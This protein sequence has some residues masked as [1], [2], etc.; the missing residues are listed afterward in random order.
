MLIKRKL[1]LLAMVSV[2]VTA[3]AAVERIEIKERAP[4]APGVTYGEAG[5]YEKIRGIAYFALDPK[6]AANAAIVDLKRAPRDARGRVLFSSEFI[7]LRPAGGLPSSLIYDVNNRGGIAMLGQ[8]NGRSPANND[9]ATAADAGDGFLMR[10]GFSMLFSAW[11]WDVAPPAPGARPLVFAPP[12][13]QGVKGRVQNEFTVNAPVDIATY[14]GMRGLTYEPATPNDPHAQL[15]MRARPGD[16]RRLVPR[17]SWHFVAPEQ[18]G[19]PGRVRLDDGFKPDT[20]YE[21]TYVAKDPYVTGAGLAGIR[22]LLAY[23]RDKPFEGAPVPKNVL[24]FGISQSGRVIGRMLHDGLN[25]DESGQLVFSGAY[26]HVP[27][28]GGSAGF[29]SRFAQP[30]RHPSM[31]EE[32][33]YP[34]DAFPF[35]TAPSRDPV[36]GQT[37][38]YLDH[39][40]DKQGRL[41]KL[42]IA[43]TSTEFWNRGASLIA[44][45]PDGMQ[46]VAPADNVRIYGFMGAQH[47]VGRSR[48]R[49]P[50]T[51]CVSTSDHYLPMRALVLAL[52]DWTSKGKQPPASAYPQLADRTL[53][54]VADYRAI[55]PAGLGLT[56][57]EQNL[58]E[59]RLD[60]GRRFAKQG[61]AD[62]VPPD[63]GDEY[64]TRVP[65]P[66]ADGN[67]KGGVRLVEVQ[68]PLGTHTG[69]NL[70][71]PETGFAWA[72]SRFDGSFVPFARTEAERAVSG[73]PR[74][75]LE[76]RYPT[77]DDFVAAVRA[78]AQR[79]IAAG[80]LLPED[81]DRTLTGNAGLYD[82]IMQHDPA[83]KGCAYLY[84]AP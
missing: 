82:R 33:D 49:A 80:L 10:H 56:P 41:P 34:A 12:L 6:A 66:D 52:D 77:R 8:I 23:F 18:A 46:D 73:D 58:R 16:K 53:T 48:T 26:L 27:G 70:R 24:M 19:G 78:A 79:Q 4:F 35:T 65:V 37:A 54:T 51:A 83:D 38:S 11:T 57:P 45:T 68:A 60:F 61:I 59:P 32:H 74:P 5:A 39:A 84:A 20:I 62:K 71:A 3:L 81:M 55:F 14:A 17:S 9:P 30:T 67:D 29:N 31:L 42:I 22:D 25:V 13:A 43:N 72:T 21:L 1:A 75:S 64:E 69:W 7:L 63:S 47:Y 15:T 2:S 76:A 36:S 50:F 28:A 40:R 44:T